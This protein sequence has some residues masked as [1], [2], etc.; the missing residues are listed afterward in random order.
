MDIYEVPITKRMKTEDSS[1]VAETITSTSTARERNPLS[2]LPL[3]E[4][5]FDLL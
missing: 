5:Y 1:T 3:S 4:N 2:G